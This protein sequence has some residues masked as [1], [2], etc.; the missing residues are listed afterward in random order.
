MMSEPATVDP[1]ASEL[2]ELRARVE[3]L[4]DL[5]DFD[6]AVIE[7]GGKPLLNWA[8]AKSELGL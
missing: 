7:N 2:Q 4:E 5:R 3:E 8:D 1:L 6:A